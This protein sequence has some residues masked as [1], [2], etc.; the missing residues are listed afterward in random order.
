MRGYPISSLY[1]T[2]KSGIAGRARVAVTVAKDL[3]T[4]PKFYSG[5]EQVPFQVNQKG[6]PEIAASFPVLLLLKSL[7]R[8]AVIFFRLFSFERE[9]PLSKS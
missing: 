1:S 5:M 9:L 2:S 8:D 6:S 3:E 7:K 4:L